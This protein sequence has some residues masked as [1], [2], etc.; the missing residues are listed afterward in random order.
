MKLSDGSPMFVLMCKDGRYGVFNTTNSKCMGEDLSYAEAWD[1]K[2]RLDD[3]EYEGALAKW[4]VTGGPM[5][6]HDSADFND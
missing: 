4:K 3:Q 2:Y 1:L 5:P 6:E